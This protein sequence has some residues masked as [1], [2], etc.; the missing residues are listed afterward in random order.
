MPLAPLFVPMPIIAAI[1]FPA[2]LPIIH[3]DDDRNTI[4]VP[5]SACIDTEGNVDFQAHPYII[6]ATGGY[7]NNGAPAWRTT[8]IHCSQFIT[9]QVIS[10]RQN[11]LPMP[12]QGIILGG[13]N[14][15]LIL[16]KSNLKTEIE[17]NKLFNQAKRHAQAAAYAEQIRYTP[18]ELRREFHTCALK[19]WQ[20][21]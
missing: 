4:A 13:R 16:P 21:I 3:Y 12:L 15:V 6:L 19:Q 1:G 11:H 8:L 5:G 10:N 2:L 14:S 18:P 9:P 17:L 7:D 20:E